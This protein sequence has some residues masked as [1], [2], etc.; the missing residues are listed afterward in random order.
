VNAGVRKAGPGPPQQAV[1]GQDGRREQQWQHHH[2]EDA[3][4]PAPPERQR[5][6]ARA[7]GI[8]EGVKIRQVGADDQRRGA[9][10]RRALQSRLGQCQ[11]DQRVG[12]VI[13]G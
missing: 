13:H 9:Q 1:P 4:G 5:L 7:H 2:G 10:R 12:D 6:G 11:T 3:V 8:D